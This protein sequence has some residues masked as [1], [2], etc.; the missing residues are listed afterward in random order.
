MRRNS[1]AEYWA[2][3]PL[4]R[5]PYQDFTWAILARCPYDQARGKDKIR[6][7][8]AFIMADTET[9]KSHEDSFYIESDG[10]K[11]FR[12]NPNYIVCWTVSINIMGMDI[13]CLRGRTPSQLMEC[14]ALLS[15]H[16]PGNRTVIYWHNFS[17]DYLF[18]RKFLFRDFGEPVKA[19]NTKPHYPI[20]MDFANGL[21]FRDS[22]ILAQRGLEKWADDM[23][24]LHRKAVGNW[25]YDKIR[26]QDTPLTEDEWLYVDNDTLAGVE[27]LDKTRRTIGCTH[28]GMPYTATGIVRNGARKEGDSHNAHRDA[29]NQY[30]DYEQYA[31]F[32]R[33]Y[34]G[35]YTH[36]N[37]HIVNHTISEELDGVPIEAHDFASSYPFC[38][39][40][41]KYPMER[42]TPMGYDP[43]PEEILKYKDNEAFIFTL[44]MRKLHLKDPD[45]PFPV[46]QVSKADLLVDAII[47]NGRIMEAGYL[48][49][50]VNEITFD[51]IMR[52]YEAEEIHLSN[53]LFAYK[54]YLPR[55]L[56]DYIYQLYKDKTQLKGGDPVL[57]AIRKAMLNSI[58][59]MSVQKL[60]KDDIEEDYK[61]G[62][63][64]QK[65]K[66]DLVAEFEKIMKQ[67][68]TFLCYHWGVW[69]TSY[70]QHNLFDMIECTHDTVFDALYCD[71]DS[72]YALNWNREKL[73]AYNTRC[74]EKLV[75]NGYGAVEFNGK[76]YWLG[77]ASLDGVYS[78]FRALGAKRYACRDKESG[79]LKITVAGVPKKKGAEC[80][81]DDI[82]NFKPGFAFSGEITGKLTH[83]YQYVDAIYID[84]NGNE[85]GDSVN[86]I[87]CDYLLDQTVEQRIDSFVYQ[88]VY[89]QTYDAEEVL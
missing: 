13:A 29:V 61:T 12:D 19:L 53:C 14:F 41:E 7:N 63:Y 57:Y 17:Y 33:L 88:E 16:L 72:C 5:G 25:D 47:D 77:E 35:G 21:Q 74:R 45:W 9:S 3:V 39:L 50:D 37:R 38:Q 58:Y 85:I 22:L 46:L 87:P 70:A 10:T 89:I 42:F 30:T 4:Y 81:K 56:T 48:K 11:V 26:N 1:L 73:E 80:L 24:V 28:A 23:Q 43:E 36:A 65:P 54:A 52:Y 32:E 6:L 64:H 86:L 62:E 79:K 27:C 15:R 78:E 76:E 69:I 18:I 51:L 60:I 67:R 55:W 82:E 83:V 84:V 8:E 44:E 31:R 75:A 68:S 2:G 20:I 40:S 49:M 71:T 66:A 59:G 34:H